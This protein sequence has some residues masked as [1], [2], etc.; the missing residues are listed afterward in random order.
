MNTKPTFKVLSKANHTLVT[1]D[2]TAQQFMLYVNEKGDDAI[3]ITGHVQ[4][5]TIASKVR[6]HDDDSLTFC[7]ILCDIVTG[8][9]MEYSI[10]IPTGTELTKC[11]FAEEMLQVVGHALST[12]GWYQPEF[13]IKE[14]WRTICLHMD[15][16]MDGY[17]VE[18]DMFK[19]YMENSED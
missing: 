19:D 7:G 15:A 10:E 17:G 1:K 16:V 8:N 2:S 4:D 14:L 5:V 11:K 12:A 3:S 18:L 9:S 6:K 13:R